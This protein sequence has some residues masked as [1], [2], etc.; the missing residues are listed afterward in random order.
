MSAHRSGERS[1]S[2]KAL[3]VGFL[4][5]LGAGN[6][7]NDA[8][9][10]SILGYLRRVHPEA[11]LGAMCSGPER[12]REIYGVDAVPLHYHLREEPETWEG[13]SNQGAAATR[14]RPGIT[15]AD[16]LGLEIAIGVARIA[17]WVRKQDV[18]IVPGAGVLESA[19]LLRPWGTPLQM[20]VLCLSG[21]I[22]RTKVALVC[23]GATVSNDRLT[24]LLFTSAAKL[25]YYRSFRD[26]VSRDAMRQQGVDT[27]QDQVYADLAFGI[28]PLEQEAAED[29]TTVGVGVMAFYGNNDER[30]QSKAIHEAYMQRLKLFVRKIVDGGRKVRFFVGDSNGGDDSIAQEVMADLRSYRPDLDQ[31]SATVAVTH[32]FADLMRAMAPV[33][34]VVAT[35][36]HNVICA[37][38]LTKLT[39]AVGYSP[40]HRVL[41]SDLGMTGYSQGVNEFDVDLLLK[42]LDELEGRSTELRQAMRER[43]AAKGRLLEKQFAE[44]SAAL[45]NA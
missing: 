12:V 5:I 43:H 29:S 37:L 38:K 33:G 2:G 25:A 41:M 13:R 1:R 20:F 22:F 14:K 26:D 32:S 31:A 3:K 28:P 44:L 36:Y 19:L 24:R 4:G 40:K 9:F 8:Q 45:L 39:V 34:F 15:K 27:S 35:R 21:R 11:V 42:Q 23:V 17:S 10:E 16:R 6:I 18:V 30:K 7:G